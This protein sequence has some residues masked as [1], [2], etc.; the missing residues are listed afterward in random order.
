MKHDA[1]KVDI[2]DVAKIQLTQSESDVLS[3]LALAPNSTLSRCDQHDRAVMTG[4]IAKGLATST[5]E[6]SWKITEMGMQRCATI[7][8]LA[9]VK[10]RM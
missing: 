1:S 10:P 6:E 4:L 7:Y 5:G 3:K 9:R 2:N 8:F